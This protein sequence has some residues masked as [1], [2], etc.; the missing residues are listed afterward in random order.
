MV[1]TGFFV[2]WCLVLT[3]VCLQGEHIHVALRKNASIHYCCRSGDNRSVGASVPVVCRWLW[4]GN[5]TLSEMASMVDSGFFAQFWIPG[6]LG[7]ILWFYSIL[8]LLVMH[9]KICHEDAQDLILL[10]NIHYAKKPLSTSEP[11]ITFLC[12]SWSPQSKW[13][14]LL[15]QKTVIH[16]GVCCRDMVI[17]VLWNYTNQAERALLV[18]LTT[19]NGTMILVGEGQRMFIW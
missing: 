13:R 18:W 4:P 2:L 1:V 17:Y 8:T 7:L 6:S 12:K 3:L 10:H 14:V 11:V 15:T 5:R 19:T 9:V 16:V